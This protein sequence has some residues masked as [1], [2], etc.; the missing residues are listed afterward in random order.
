ME[1]LFSAAQHNPDFK[2]IQPLAERARPETLEN[3]VGQ[4]QVLGEGHLLKN[5]FLSDRL[6][7]LI[8]WGPPG[9][10]KTTFANLVSKK[11]KATFVN[12]SAIDTGA[13]ELKTEGEEARQRL[14]RFNEKTILF[15][16]EIHRLNK[17][18]QDVLLPYIEKGYLSL[19][20]ATTENPS[21]ELNQALLSRC[22]VIVFESL[23]PEALDRVLD[24]GLALLDE[25][26][27]WSD[28]SK[29]DVR[30]II[31]EN[32]LGDGR[33]ALNL[34]ENLYSFYK[35]C[36][37]KPLDQSHVDEA[38]KHIP[39]RYDKARD[40]HYDTISAFIKSIR[41]SDPDAALYYMVRMLKGGEDPLFIAR[42]LVILAS[43]DIGNADPRAV[44]VATAV[45]DAVD[46]VG[47]PEAAIGLAQAVTYLAT[48]P[49]SNRSYMGLKK[50]EALLERYPNEDIPMSIRN[51]P[52]KMMKNLGYGKNYQYAHDSETGV[53]PQNFMPDKLRGNKLYEP[54]TRGHEKNVTAYMEWVRAQ[55][56]GQGEQGGRDEDLSR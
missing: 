28:L 9:T 50:A 49:K 20:G 30:G 43:E 2:R 41:G 46:F 23:G 25:K 7:S 53:T 14:L 16:D 35:A 40:M 26:I 10:G 55:L 17:A 42:R 22:Q 27:S 38:L 6:P 21:F 12:R 13:K 52:T 37:S 1:D 32:A 51:A 31:T 48:A 47:M 36:G 3:F 45:K 24:R 44:M 34:L 33:R 54:T 56:A 29:T 15:I 19:I 11:T 8:L 5:L 39:I 4:N 18:Q